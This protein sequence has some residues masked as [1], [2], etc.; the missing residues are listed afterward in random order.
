MNSFMQEL[1]V[2]SE[3]EIQSRFAKLEAGWEIVE[4]KKLR[5]VFAFQT[6]REAV[7]FVVRVADVVERE[8]HYPEIHLR[9]GKITLELTTEAVNGLSEADFAIA[10]QIDFT[11]NWKEIVERFVFTKIFSLGVLVV[12]VLMLLIILLWKKYF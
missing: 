1:K 4:A 3:E 11:Y 5:R 9:Y 6:F 2:L 8:K 7:D 10:K 12:I